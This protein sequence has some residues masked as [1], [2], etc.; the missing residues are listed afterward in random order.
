MVGAALVTV[1]AFPLLPAQILLNS[2][3]EDVRDSREPPPIEDADGDDHKLKTFAQR[4]ILS[5]KRHDTSM[6]HN[7]PPSLRPAIISGQIT[8]I[9]QVCMAHTLTSSVR[10]YAC[11][12]CCGSAQDFEGKKYLPEK[13]REYCL[14]ILHDEVMKARAAPV[15]LCAFLCIHDK[16]VRW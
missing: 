3:I 1:C 15:F 5:K 8:R 9:L 2:F 7:F 16:D 13:S 6:Y 11:P 4:L 14:K 10:S 12:L